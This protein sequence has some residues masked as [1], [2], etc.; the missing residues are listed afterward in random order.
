MP[1]AVVAPRLVRSGRVLAEQTRCFS[2]ETGHPDGGSALRCRRPDRQCHL[3]RYSSCSVWDYNA[4]SAV[5][6]MHRH[7]LME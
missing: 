7:F 6:S 4:L 1:A 2:V 5:K 3:E